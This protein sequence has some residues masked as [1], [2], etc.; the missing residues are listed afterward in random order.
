MAPSLSEQAGRS[1]RGKPRMAAPSPNAAKSC[2]P[3]QLGGLAAHPPRQTPI[4][5]KVFLVKRQP[6]IYVL[7]TYLKKE[8][9]REKNSALNGRKQIHPQSVYVEG[10]LVW[11]GESPAPSKRAWD[12]KLSPRAPSSSGREATH[13]CASFL[14]VWRA[15]CHSPLLRPGEGCH[16]GIVGCLMSP[17]PELVQHRVGDRLG[18]PGMCCK[19]Q[20][21]LPAL[22]LKHMLPPGPPGLYTPDLSGSMGRGLCRGEA[23]LGTPRCPWSTDDGHLHRRPFSQTLNFPSE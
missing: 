21:L 7:W 16:A 1:L 13:K 12:D 22:G 2:Q 3:P 18:V 14:A 5:Q 20:P 15:G 9:R 6:P 23:I 11:W 4:E 17:S 19:P 8:K 10:F